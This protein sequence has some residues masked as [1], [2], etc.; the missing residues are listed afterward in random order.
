MRAESTDGVLRTTTISP[1]FVRTDLA[2]SMSGEL[3]ERTR[4]GMSRFG[5][6]A[7]AVARTVVFAVEQPDDVEISSL[8]VA[9]TVQ[10]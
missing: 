7:E 5:I 9:P 3:R 10:G 2:D 4:E 8:V 6:P 1:G